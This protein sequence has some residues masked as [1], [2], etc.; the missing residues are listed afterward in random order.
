MPLA[1]HWYL[2]R[3]EEDKWTED[4]GERFGLKFFNHDQDDE[5]KYVLGVGAFGGGMKVASTPFEIRGTALFREL[6]YSCSLCPEVIRTKG[7]APIHS[8]HSYYILLY[9]WLLQLDTTTTSFLLL[10]RNHYSPNK[11]G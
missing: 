11:R 6:L 3:H 9:L 4:D 1:L 2:K 8:L 10:G 7:L 5:E